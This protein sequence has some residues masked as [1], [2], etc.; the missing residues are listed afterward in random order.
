MI[1]RTLEKTR[2]VA[3]GTESL[4]AS[5]WWLHNIAVSL[6][7]YIE[8]SDTYFADTNKFFL[9]NVRSLWSNGNPVIR[10]CVRL[11]MCGTRYQA[12]LSH[13]GSSVSNPIPVLR[14]S[15]SKEFSDS[16]SLDCG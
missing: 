7:P 11:P 10:L 8:I 16:A 6:R 5:L 3:F 9:V 13:K 12:V 15:Y 4:V 2:I 1:K 14:T